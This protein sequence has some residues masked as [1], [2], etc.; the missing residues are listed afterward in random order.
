MIYVERRPG[1]A[2]AP[3]IRTLW[4]TKGYQ[5]PHRRERVLPDC[6]IQMIISLAHEYILDCEKD[7]PMAPA[8]IAGVHSRYV[9][10]DTAGLSEMIGIQ[11][12]AGGFAPFFGIP[13][14]EFSGTHVSLEAV[15][16]LGAR[17]LRD[18]LR[19]TL[20]PS[21][22]LEVLEETLLNWGAARVARHAIVDF[23]LGEFRGLAYAGGVGEV[24]QQTG[25]SAR[26]FAEVF[27]RQVGVTPKLYCRIRRFQRAVRQAH[28]GQEMDWAD[29]AAECGYFD[30]SHF[31]ND[32]RAFSG[33]TPGAYVANLSQWA[34]HVPI[35]E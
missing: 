1:A 15:L 17:G 27:R 23:A 20:T 6:A 9:V 11:F 14:D 28:R 30:Q 7:V 13:A 26:R 31:V 10:I 19:E 5:A 4:Y 21:G 3:F 18:R 2:I 34:N 33:I 24:T 12:Q 35:Y 16:G 8:L 22:K 29:V 25:L 32:F